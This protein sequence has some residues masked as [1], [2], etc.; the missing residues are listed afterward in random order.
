[1]S[2][3]IQRC[4]F[5]FLNFL[6]FRVIDVTFHS[7]SVNHLS[8]A[9][10]DEINAAYRRLSRMYHPDKHVEAEQKKKA[11]LLFSKIKKAYEGT[12]IKKYFIFNL[13]ILL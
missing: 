6:L 4:E 13:V 12:R 8:K 9:S 1:M 10:Q 11:D 2:Q 5:A 3:Y 7:T